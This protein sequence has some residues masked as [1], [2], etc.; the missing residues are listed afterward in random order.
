MKRIFSSLALA[1]PLTITGCNTMDS[2]ANAGHYEVR[3]DT[4]MYRYGPAQ[5]FGP[6][7]TLKQGQHLILMRKDYGYSRIMTDENQT[8][9]VATKDILPSKAPVVAYAKRNGN[10]ASTHTATTSRYNGPKSV[11]VRGHFRKDGSYVR[12]HTRSKAR[13]R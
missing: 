3:V 10:S 8:G 5:S 2:A 4:P 1:L 12:P 11:Y 7:S 6:D 13:R 9:Y